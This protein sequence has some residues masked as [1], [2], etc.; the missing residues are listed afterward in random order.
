MKLF[1][2]GEFE[3][4]VITPPGYKGPT[5]N[6]GLEISQGLYFVRVSTIKF[7][8]KHRWFVFIR[9]GENDFEARQLADQ[10]VRAILILET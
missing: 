9:E 5:G 1:M 7:G 8:R 10:I 6:G 3:E 2:K 4:A